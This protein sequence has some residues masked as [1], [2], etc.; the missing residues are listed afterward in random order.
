M[1]LAPSVGSRPLILVVD[2][3]ESLR[4]VITRALLRAGYHVLTAATYAQ[5]IELV[6]RLRVQP[7]AAVIDLHLPVVPGEGVA[8]ELRRR[9]PDL[10]LLFVSAGGHDQ[11]EVL[12]GLLLEKPFSLNTLCYLVGNLLALRA[13]G[14][15]LHSA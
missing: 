2:D 7:Q 13:Q 5:A 6:D 8:A 14:M 3:L 11:D 1:R 15:P 12:P 4:R 10:P 9:A